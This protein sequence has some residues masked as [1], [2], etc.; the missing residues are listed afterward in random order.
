MPNWHVTPL[1]QES[2]HRFGAVPTQFRIYRSASGCIGKARHL[3]NVSSQASAGLRQLLE[4]FL[5]LRRSQVDIRNTACPEN[6]I[7]NYS[8]HC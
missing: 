6:N 2:D 1:H 8:A 4:C 5:V 3:D 7:N